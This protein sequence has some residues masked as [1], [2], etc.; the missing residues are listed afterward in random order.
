MEVEERPRDGVERER[1]TNGGGFKRKSNEQSNLKT[2]S[3]LKLYKFL[4]PLTWLLYSGQES[5][6]L[7]RRRSREW[8]ERQISSKEEDILTW[9]GMLGRC[10]ALALLIC[11]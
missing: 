9:D 6:R 7:G 3:P 1:Q 2:S 10:H 8:G 4:S 11:V 5:R